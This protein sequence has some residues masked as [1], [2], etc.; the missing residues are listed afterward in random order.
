MLVNNNKSNKQTN[1]DKNKTRSIK[2][3]GLS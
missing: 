2:D 1:K 3:R